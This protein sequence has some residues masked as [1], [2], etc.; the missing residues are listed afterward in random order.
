MNIRGPRKRMLVIGVAGL[1]V[2]IVLFVPTLNPDEKA[3]LP[4]ARIDVSELPPGAFFEEK[5]QSSRVFILRNFDRQFHVFVVPYREGAY[6][7]LE[8]DWSRPAV[9]CASTPSR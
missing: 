5:L 2:A 7:L 6:W 9:P 1:V 4:R 3:R 8:F